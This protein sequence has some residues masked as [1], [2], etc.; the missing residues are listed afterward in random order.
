MTGRVCPGATR[1]TDLGWAAISK[2]YVRYQK[3]YSV[4]RGREGKRTALWKKERKKE[5]DDR[6]GQC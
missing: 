6:D 2:D 4:N 5:R 1:G 3:S